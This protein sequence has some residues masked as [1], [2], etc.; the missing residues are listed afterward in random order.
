MEQCVSKN[1]T[2]FK[3]AH[4][5]IIQTMFDVSL[6]IL[7]LIRNNRNNIN[8]VWNIFMQNNFYFSKNKILLQ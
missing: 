4:K 5:I 8:K 6:L 1:S 2:L 7:L 3:Q